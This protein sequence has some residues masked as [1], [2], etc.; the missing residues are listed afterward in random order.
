MHP[1]NLQFLLIV[2][3]PLFIQ[4]M[5]NM[6]GNIWRK[7]ISQL[8]PFCVVPDF[9]QYSSHVNASNFAM[10]SPSISQQD[11]S[12]ASMSFLSFRVIFK[13]LE[14]SRPAKALKLSQPL[15]VWK[16]IIDLQQS[17][18]TTST[19]MLTNLVWILVLHLRYNGAL[20]CG[21]KR[22]TQNSFFSSEMMTQLCVILKQLVQHG[23]IGDCLRPLE[24]KAVPSLLKKQQWS[25]CSK[26]YHRL[27]T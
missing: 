5:S 6:V 14:L 13:V 22:Q 10:R 15:D 18:F 27:L 12:S 8:I 4:T 26:L 23:A 19:C 7:P 24:L 21:E 16:P 25:A 2:T 11:P 17:E 1:V 20:I 9:G 3:G